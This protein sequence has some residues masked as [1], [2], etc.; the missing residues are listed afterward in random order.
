MSKSSDTTPINI[1]LSSNSSDNHN[2]EKNNIYENY[3]ISTNEKLINEN[4]NLTA[5][6]KEL[7]GEIIL[8]EEDFDKLENS[9]RYLKALLTNLNENRSNF[10][11]LNNHI[12]K[13]NEIY[14]K[15]SKEVQDIFKIISIYSCIL[16]FLATWILLNLYF[17]N[18]K[19]ITASIGLL[20]IIYKIYYKIHE[21]ITK[22]NKLSKSVKESTSNLNEKIKEKKND[23]K[24]I[25]DSCLTLD[26]WIN[27]V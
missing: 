17:A 13:S 19:I 8:K 2:S 11:Q 7:E 1:L 26:N 14:L 21:K 5:K 22:L 23:I 24:I 20:P 4:T 10:K 18:K 6:I 27:E 9:I 15:Y 16:V 3:L 12:I 25:E